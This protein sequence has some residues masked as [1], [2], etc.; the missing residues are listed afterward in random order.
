MT[1]FS[2]QNGFLANALE[3]VQD[4]SIAKHEHALHQYRL[5][6]ETLFS[7]LQRELS[8]SGHVKHFAEQAALV[9][10]INQLV[11]QYARYAYC[12]HQ[13]KKSQAEL[14]DLSTQKNSF[15]KK[16]FFLVRFFLF[17]LNAMFSNVK[18]GDSR[19]DASAYGLN[20]LPCTLI[21]PSGQKYFCA[22]AQSDDQAENASSVFYLNIN[23]T[24][25]GLQRIKYGLD[26]GVY[27]AADAQNVAALP[28]FVAGS[29]LLEP[30]SVALVSDPAVAPS[31]A[32]R[33]DGVIPASHLSSVLSGAPVSVN[34]QDSE[35]GSNASRDAHV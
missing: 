34:E 35:H 15:Y 28:S 20:R 13:A 5:E 1:A 26:Q 27:A 17:I 9:D 3:Y 14:G 23:T 7:A 6:A 31:G 22:F 32:V 11:T 25:K 2:G 12:Q 21:L 33:S 10:S 18:K 4:A 16:S 8:A 29:V 24:D 19:H 30:F